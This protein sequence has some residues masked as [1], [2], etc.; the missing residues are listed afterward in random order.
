MRRSIRLR[1]FDYTGPSTYFVTLVSASR[2]RCFARVRHGQTVLGSWGRIV[3]EEWLRSAEIRDYLE[4][5]AFVIMPDHLHAIVRFTRPSDLPAGLAH[6]GL[7]R[8][9]R[10]LGSYIARFKASCTRRINLLRG[11][12][13]PPIWQRNYYETIIRSAAH[14]DRVRRYIEMNPIAAGRKP[15]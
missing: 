8:P 2:L 3:Q 12:T 15:A 4:L 7:Y 5:D 14:L 6:T 10:S 11:C 13:E 1:G 9:P